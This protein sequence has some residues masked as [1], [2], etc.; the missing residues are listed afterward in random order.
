MSHDTSPRLP[1]TRLALP[2]AGVV[3]LLAGLLLAVSTERG[4]AGFH[5]AAARHG[6]QV[7][8]L[9]ADGGPQPGDQGLMVRV[10]G[11]A[12]VVEAPL[13]AQ[14]NQQVDTPGL[15]RRVA[16]F[17]WHEVSAGGPPVYEQDWIDHPV[18]SSGFAPGH[19]NPGRF[20]LQGQRIDAGQVRVGRFVLSR[21]IQRA[22]PGSVPVSPDMRRL[23]ANL[24]AS[25]SLYHDALVTSANPSRPQIGDLRVSWEAV[26]VQ[27]VTVVAQVDGNRLV[28][29]GHAADGKGFEVQVGD[30]PLAGM[31]PDLPLPPAFAW[32]RRVLAVL[33]AALG[34]GLLQRHRRGEARP[35]PAL[36]TGVAAVG[37]VS[38]LCWLGTAVATAAGWFVLAALGIALAAWLH[39]GRR[40]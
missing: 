33:L 30:R 8:D 1:S 7:L 19:A 37:V 28:P 2:V 25:F 22:L 11:M 20:P 35:L 34:L 5:A 15:V 21:E 16:M 36:A 4:L 26:P 39:G 6:G 23:P 31:F 27:A 17:Q 40:L 12:Q 9:G 29:A 32:P 14:F 10:S 24:A 13:D 18:D 3:L 38:G